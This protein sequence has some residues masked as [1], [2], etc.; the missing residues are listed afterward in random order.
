MTGATT[1]L[2]APAVAGD[3][4]Y[5]LESCAAEAGR[6]TLMRWT[7]AT[8]PRDLTPAPIN[9]GSRVHEYG[10]GAY[11]VADGI[12]IFSDKRDGSL[13]SLPPD[14]VPRLVA[15]VEGCRYA[16]FQIDGDRALA[17][18]EDHR[19]RPANDPKA[20]IVALDLTGAI[21]PSLNEGVI[22]VEGPDF[23]AAPRLSPDRRHL[24]WLAWDHPAMPW[25]GTRLY[26]APLGADRRLGE[27]ILVAGA[28]PEAIVQPE[29]SPDNILHFSG[30]RSGWWNLYAWRDGAVAPVTTL[31]AEIGGP[32]W[33]FGARWYAFTRDGDIVCTVIERG[34]RR[35]ARLRAGT[36]ALQPLPL[37]QIAECPL[38]VG[39]G[40][41]Y[42]SAPPDAP[43]ALLLRADADDAAPLRVARSAPD[44][45]RAEDI[46]DRGRPRRPWFLL[47]AAP[48]RY[49]RAKR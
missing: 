15:A 34:I 47:R 33:Q 13:W 44:Y 19:G 41:A 17:I 14:G 46:A 43:T 25:D 11:A 8:G 9:I 36:S 38:P 1:S 22:L 45:L 39:A 42:L 18:R 5:W 32:M 24:A 4:L 16:D 23:L 2:S 37:G 29:W 7:E 27:A 10:G 28:A 40:L 6:A 26:A 21:D 20:A 12:I 31:A 30:D 3:A 48:C 49:R 35:A